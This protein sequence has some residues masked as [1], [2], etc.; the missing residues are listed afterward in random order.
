MSSVFAKFKF[1]VLLFVCFY[2]VSSVE[3]PAGRGDFKYVQRQL[4]QYDKPQIKNFDEILER[5]GQKSYQN[6]LSR[7]LQPLCDAVEIENFQLMYDLLEAG[8]SPNDPDCNNQT[9]MYFAAERGRD[10]MLGELLKRGGNISLLVS[11]GNDALSAAAYNGQISCVKML[12]RH[13]YPFHQRNQKGR[14]AFDYACAAIRHSSLD[15]KNW[16]KR[17]TGIKFLHEQDRRLYT[18]FRLLRYVMRK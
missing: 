9:P 10:D 5:N 3:E 7:G 2:K 17:G 12:L 4:R 1:F 15:T 11:K 8:L 13:G 18:T 6:Y 14:T 16:G